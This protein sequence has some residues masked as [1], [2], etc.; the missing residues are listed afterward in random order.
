MSARSFLVALGVGGTTFL[1]VIGVV[2]GYL[3]GEYPAAL[4]ALPMG[5]AA[6]FLATAIAY[7]TLGT[8]TS[9]A[10]Q[11]AIAGLAAFWYASFVLW[12]LRFTTS[13]LRPFLPFEL[14]F[15][16]GAV[17]AVAVVGYTW[18]RYPAFLAWS[19]P[20]SSVE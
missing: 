17:A 5:V 12:L 18:S 16:V 11:S 6:I 8:R 10:A 3:G 9:K 20:R 19:F 2:F 1:A 14:V 7:R 13:A 4:Y 15:A